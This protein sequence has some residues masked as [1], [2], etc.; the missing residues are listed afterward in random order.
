MPVL[1]VNIQECILDSQEYGSTDQHM[2][3]RVF[4]TIGADDKPPT[5]DHCDIKQVVGS[6]YSPNSVEVGHPA[7]YKGPYDHE[8]F[9]S[10]VAEYFC[11]LVNSK[12]AVFSLGEATSVRMMNTRFTVPHRFTFNAEGAGPGW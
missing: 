2:V 8:K 6:T 11:K 9:A 1:N 7:K 3:S 12:G 4:F 10:E 5:E